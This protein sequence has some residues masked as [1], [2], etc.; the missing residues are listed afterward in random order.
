MNILIIL[1]FFFEKVYFMPNIKEGLALTNFFPEAVVPSP[2]VDVN[3]RLCAL[4]PSCAIPSE[5]RV[6]Y[7]SSVVKKCCRRQP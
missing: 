7:S 3:D 2:P 6:K 4:I 1:I 5:K